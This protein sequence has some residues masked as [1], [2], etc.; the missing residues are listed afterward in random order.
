MNRYKA[1]LPSGKI[2]NPKLEIAGVDL[3]IDDVVI[4]SDGVVM[5]MYSEDQ[6][7]YGVVAA[8]SKKGKKV[9]IASQPQELTNETQI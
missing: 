4:L 6:T 3:E 1:R 8:D 9:L 2:K 5:P 7:M